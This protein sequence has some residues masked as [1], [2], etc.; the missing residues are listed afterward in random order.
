LN[1]QD[2]LDRADRSVVVHG[3][4]VSSGSDS[5]LYSAMFSYQNDLSV[6]ALFQDGGHSTTIVLS[7]TDEAKIGRLVVWNDH[8]APLIYSI[9]KSKIMGIQDPK[10]IRDING[11]IPDLVGNRK[12]PGFTWQ[13]LENIFGSDPAL[14]AFMRGRKT[15]HHP[16]PST[17]EREWTCRFLSMVPGSTLS[18]FWLGG[19]GGQP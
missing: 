18:L 6:F 5:A 11:K 16:Q 17:A 13:E 15:T 10:D 14:L 9:D 3:R 4:L 7:D 1:A 8:D 19:G 2:F 12:P